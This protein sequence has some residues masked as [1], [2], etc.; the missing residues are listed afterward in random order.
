MFPFRKKENGGPTATAAV[1]AAVAAESDQSPEALQQR[2][3]SLKDK[4]ERLEIRFR[5]WYADVA[6]ADAKMLLG[7]TNRC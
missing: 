6:D 7:P 5:G 2:I 4:N 1:A 3:V